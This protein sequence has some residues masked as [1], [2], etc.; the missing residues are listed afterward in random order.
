MHDHTSS[1]EDGHNQIFGD[2]IGF[3]R[4]GNGSTNREAELVESNSAEEF[5]QRFVRLWWS[6]ETGFPELNRI[7]SKKEQKLNEKRLQHALDVLIQETQGESALQARR[8]NDHRIIS[9]WIDFARPVLGIQDHHIEALR[10]YGFAEA[11]LT[12]ANMARDFDPSIA[13]AEIFQA[14]RNVWSMNFIQLLFG[15]PVEITPAIFAYSLLYPY[16]DNY[17]DDP[18]ISIEMKADFIRRLGQRLNG[19]CPKPE[20]DGEAKIY[21]LIEMIERQYQRDRYPQV[22]ASLAAIHHSQHRSIQ[23]ID[24][25][26]SPYE[27]DRLGICFDKGGTSVLA[28]GYL[29]AGHLTPEQQEL[30]FFYGTFTQLVDDLED[31]EK[32]LNAGLMTVFSQ[33]A[34]H[35][36]LDGV[37][38][39]TYRY[40]LEF[41]EALNKV[42]GDPLI[43]L[44]EVIRLAIAPMLFL[45]VGSFGRH[46]SRA[47]RKEIQ[48]Y[49]PVRFS[50]ANKLRRKLSRRGISPLGLVEIFAD[51]GIGKS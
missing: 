30:V 37:T 51:S 7:Y 50:Y 14:S 33:T 29:V 36:P 44:K 25:S 31:I 15:L 38:N 21:E 16:T 23:L 3:L 10:S 47:Y 28:D 11:I 18:S 6:L 45:S 17:L 4:D 40:G 32:D 19:E 41:L 13:E 9:A 22:F 42:P 43:P 26:A 39:R 35:W 8:I 27:V 12:F 49:F 2:S 46:Y 48:R 5:L 1:R 20:N 24:Q 34:N